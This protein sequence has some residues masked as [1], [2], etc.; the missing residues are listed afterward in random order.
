MLRGRVLVTS[1]ALGRAYPGPADPRLGVAA[2]TGRH[3]VGW[4]RMKA[5]VPLSGDRPHRTPRLAPFVRWR[6]RMATENNQNAGREEQSHTKSSVFSHAF[7]GSPGKT[8]TQSGQHR[9]ALSPRKN[10]LA[11][12][13]AG[14]IMC[15]GTSTNRAF[16]YTP[17]TPLCSVSSDLVS[18]LPE[19]WDKPINP[20]QSGRLRNDGCPVPRSI[21]ECEV[22][23]SSLRPLRSVVCA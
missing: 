15:T 18:T 11:L 22:S 9:P 6:A 17:A 19:K 13:F 10:N 20:S 5:Y 23:I 7:P 21:R 2:C 12:R 4:D 16:V 3:G 1:P 14:C 8:Q